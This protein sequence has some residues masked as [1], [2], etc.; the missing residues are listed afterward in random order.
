MQGEITRESGALDRGG[1]GELMQL[2]QVLS[3]GAETLRRVRVA[4]LGL[5][6]GRPL[7]APEIT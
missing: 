6:P 1:P 2:L 7:K 5:G 4:G 3:L